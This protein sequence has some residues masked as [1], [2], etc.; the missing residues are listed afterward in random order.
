MQEFTIWALICAVTISFPKDFSVD[1]VLPNQIFNDKSRKNR[2]AKL[3]QPTLSKYT[4][5]SK[6]DM[7]Y[8]WIAKQW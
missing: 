8:V 1:H 7:E 6:T 5:H 4:G 3:M 2:L